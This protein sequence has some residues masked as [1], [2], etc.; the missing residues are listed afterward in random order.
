MLHVIGC[1]L[2]ADTRRSLGALSDRTE[3]N[4]DLNMGNISSVLGDAG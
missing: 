1:V 3:V 4:M 2:W